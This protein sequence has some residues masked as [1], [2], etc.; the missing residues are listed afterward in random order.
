MSRR[1]FIDTIVHKKIVFLAVFFCIFTVSYLI[2]VAIDFVP[3][4]K[5]EKEEQVTVETEAQ[6]EVQEEEDY[7]VEIEAEPV[8][9]PGAIYIKR[10]DKTIPVLNPASRNIADLDTAL[11]DGVVRHPDSAL[12]NQQGTGFILGHSSYLPNVFNQNFQAFN[13]IQNLEWGDIIEIEGENQ[14]FVYRVD[15]VFKARAQDVTVPIAV[16]EKRLTLATCNSFGSTDDRFVVEA[17]QIEV[18]PM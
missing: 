11:L 12:L 3:E 13:G 10:L 16:D 14:T 18:K 17:K 1:S 9:L 7:T 6:I 8:E 2:L 15:K 5:T 4:P